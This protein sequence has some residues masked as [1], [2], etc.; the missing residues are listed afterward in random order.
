MTSG[1]IKISDFELENVSGGGIKGT[2]VGGI[3]FSLTY[4]LGM[5]FLE[6]R[7]F[8]EDMTLNHSYL[9][10]FCQELTTCWITF[11]GSAFF[12]AIEDS[13]KNNNFRNEWTLPHRNLVQKSNTS[14][15]KII[16]NTS[17]R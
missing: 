10:E 3:V 9:L 8:S 12:D 16:K 17:C 7:I 2:I 6:S 13:F 11:I 5:R 14:V 1:I 4:G 15:S